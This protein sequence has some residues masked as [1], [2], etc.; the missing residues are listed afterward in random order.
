MT[1][2]PNVAVVDIFFN[3]KAL[4]FVNKPLLGIYTY[5]HAYHNVVITGNTDLKKT[6]NFLIKLCQ[7]ILSL[8]GNSQN[9]AF[10]VT[11]PNKLECSI[12]MGWNGLLLT[13]ILTY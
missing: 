9:F 11:G 7:E 10:F 3:D 2:T 1:N 4:T 6:G 13:H 5:D 8:G 12:T